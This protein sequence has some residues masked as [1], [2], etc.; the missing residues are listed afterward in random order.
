MTARGASW[1]EQTRPTSEKVLLDLAL[2]GTAG[3]VERVVRAARRL[4][5]GAEAQSARRSVSWRRPEDGIRAGLPARPRPPPARVGL[6]QGQDA[7]VARIRATM[8]VVEWS[9]RYS[10]TRTSPPSRST[11]GVSG[12]ICGV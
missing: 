2:S 1:S 8:A 6:I 5:A 11:T 9:D 10:S 3:H 7:A 4:A 12:S